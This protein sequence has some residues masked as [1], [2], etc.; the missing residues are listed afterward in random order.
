[1]KLSD[2]IN[3]GI[4]CLPSKTAKGLAGYLSV[5]VSDLSSARTERKGLKEEAC[6]ELAKL[7]GADPLEILAASKV[8]TAKDDEQRKLWAQYAKAAAI[9]PFAAMS[10]AFVTLIVTPSDAQA[11]PL[12]QQKSSP[13]N[14]M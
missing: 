2:A 4:E 3:K 12:H 6:L 11:A 14:I 10:I 13:I 9:G 5:S 7:I 8:I 1:M